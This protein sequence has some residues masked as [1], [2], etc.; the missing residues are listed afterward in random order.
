M[1]ITP[2]PNYPWER[3]AADL[4]E[5]K[6]SP[7]LLVAD[8]Y[9]RF[10][11]VQKLT[12][13]TSSNII[14]QL[15]TIF[16]RFGIPATMVTDNGPQFDSHEMKE[17]AQ[18][19]EFQHTTTSPYFPQSNGFAERM[20][21]TV[22]KLL[23]HTT[24]PYKSILSYRATPLPWCG[25]SPAELLMG[26]R[27]RTDIPQVKDNLIP[28]WEYIRNFKELDGKY[29]QTQ[30]DTG[31]EHFPCYQKSRLCGLIQED[32]RFLGKYCRQ[33]AHPVVETPS[34]ELRRNRAHLRIRTDPQLPMDTPVTETALPQPVTVH[35]GPVTRSQSGTVLRPPDRL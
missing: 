16:A 32:I 34:G 22:K 6:G 15:K 24:D 25:L 5:L 20:V 9:S 23:E 26:R 27:I 31:L 4:F 17:F 11:E 33:L 13:T 12:T 28:K 2:L 10:V 19:Y 30:K 29:K 18:A 14:T 21:K 1:I 8:Y 7:Y 35:S 3:I